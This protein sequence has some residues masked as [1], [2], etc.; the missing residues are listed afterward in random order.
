[1]KMKKV[2]CITIGLAALLLVAFV[3]PSVANNMNSDG[4]DLT[5]APT[6]VATASPTSA[7]IVSDE[8]KKI[9]DVDTFGHIAVVERIR[10]FSGT[11]EEKLSKLAYLE[12]EKSSSYERLRNEIEQEKK[13]KRLIL[14]EVKEFIANNGEYNEIVKLLCEAHGGADV[15][16]GSG[17]DYVEIW[18]SEDGSERIL[19]GLGQIHY[20]SLTES[21]RLY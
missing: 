3:I 12:T 14:S 17:M 20:G 2:L 7:K 6:T 15:R 11:K 1:M 19:M 10:T 21:Y 18:L 8:T 16:F 9:E 5:S 4:I 13:I